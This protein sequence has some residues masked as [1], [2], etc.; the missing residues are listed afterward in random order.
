LTKLLEGCFTCFLEF[1][2][3]F[4]FPRLCSKGQHTTVCTDYKGGYVSLLQTWQTGLG[5]SMNTHGASGLPIQLLTGLAWLGLGGAVSCLGLGCGRGASRVE[6]LAM[7]VCKVRPLHSIRDTRQSA[8]ANVE[9]LIG[10]LG[11]SRTR[12][13]LVLRGLAEANVKTS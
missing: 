3:A 8:H 4:I 9:A 5:Q 2:E 6:Y 11:S 10:T 13:L 1:G 7:L 12:K